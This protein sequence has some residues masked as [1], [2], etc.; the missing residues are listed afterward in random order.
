[1]KSAMVDEVGLRA[2]SIFEEQVP[3]GALPY[4]TPDYDILV[5]L[6]SIYLCIEQIILIVSAIFLNISEG[7]MVVGTLWRWHC[8]LEVLR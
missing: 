1:M 5:Y 8:L 2:I 7:V 4:I 3:K 6:M